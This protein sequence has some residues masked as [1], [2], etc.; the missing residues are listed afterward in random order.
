MD[1]TQENIENRVKDWHESKSSLQVHEFLG[2][3]SWQY[4]EWAKTGTLPL[5][6]PL[7]Q[8]NPDDDFDEPLGKGYC[9]LDGPCESCQ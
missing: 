5:F 4:F 2:I 1:T 3:A 8:D 7:Y 6:D 9:G